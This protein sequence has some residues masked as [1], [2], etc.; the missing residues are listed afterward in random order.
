MEHVVVNSQRGRLDALL[1]EHCN[2]GG[3]KTSFQREFGL[4]NGFFDG[5]RRS[6]KLNRSTIDKIGKA[7]PRL[8]LDW[9]RYGTGLPWKQVEE[10]D[11]SSKQSKPKEGRPYF[12]M[13]FISMF[14]PEHIT[15]TELADDYIYMNPYNKEGYYWYNITGDS[16]SPTIKNGSKIC[17]QHIPKGVDGIIYGQV[18]AIVTKSKQCTVKWVVGGTDD[19]K[20]K[21]MPENKDPKYGEYQEMDK[22]EVLHIFKVVVTVNSF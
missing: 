19:T 1:A 4:G 20:I 9:L 13:D 21:L 18:Y 22:K 14:D 17:L 8:N 2:Q 12:D 11:K 6:N 10:D 7:Q 16:M 3:N 5:Q 15:N